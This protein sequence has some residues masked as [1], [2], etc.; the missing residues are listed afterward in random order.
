MPYSGEMCQPM[1]MFILVTKSSRNRIVTPL[2]SRRDS[3]FHMSDLRPRKQFPDP[4]AN[5]VDVD[6][7]GV[8]LFSSRVKRVSRH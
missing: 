4:T 8:N 1:T 3:Y 7:T 6:R 5:F 2:A